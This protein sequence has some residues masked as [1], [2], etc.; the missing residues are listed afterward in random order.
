MAT[1]RRW[2]ANVISST[3]PSKAVSCLAVGL[4]KPLTLRT[5][6]RAAARI[7]SSVATSSAWRRVLMLRHTSATI[8]AEGSAAAVRRQLGKVG[9]RQATRIET[10]TLEHRGRQ[11]FIA[12]LGKVADGVRARGHQL[13][14]AQGGHRTKRE[15]G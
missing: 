13:P 15:H 5:N 3:A 10:G 2:D 12:T 11:A 7:S 6:W 14:E 4:V 1:S 8:D 9:R